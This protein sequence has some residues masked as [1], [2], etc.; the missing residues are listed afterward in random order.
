MNKALVLLIIISLLI[1]C[2]GKKNIHNRVKL[3]KDT[4]AFDILMGQ[5]AHNIEN[6][7]GVNELLITG[8]KDYVKYINQY[9]TRSHINFNSGNITIET[10]SP[11]NPITSLKKAIISTLLMNDDLNLMEMYSN[12]NHINNIKDS[13][14]PFLYG[15]VLDHTKQPIRWYGRAK[16]FANYLIQNKL[17]KRTSEGHVIYSI[18]IKLVSNHIDQRA[19]KYFDIIRHASKKYGI[20][21]SLIIAI[22][23]I[24]SSFNPYA[25]SNSNALGLMQIIQHTAGKDV[26]VKQGKYGVP[27]RSDL[28]N[29]EKN[30]DIGTAY[31]AILQNNYLCGIHNPASRR[32]AV[33]TAYNE[34]AGNVLRMFSSDR[35]CAVGII[36]NLTPKDVYNTIIKKQPLGE[37]H[38]Y[39]YKVNSIHKHIGMKK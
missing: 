5:F 6:I 36:N 39:L 20:D 14:K 31:L 27:S 30:I 1:A 10:I 7:W 8:P 2:S 16:N 25:V 19:H 15:Q 3:I 37:S 22:I 35:N 17:I 24:E 9:F 11:I 34:G 26:F 23:Q 32:Y 28:F 38:L 4:N 33:I 21:E 12:I 13:K 29:P 18:T